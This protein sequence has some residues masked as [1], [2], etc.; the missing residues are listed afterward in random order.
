MFSFVRPEESRAGARAA[1]GDPGADPPGAGDPLP[2]RRHRRRRPRGR[3]GAQV[4]L[5]GLD[6][7]PGAL[8]RGD[9]LLEHDGLPGAAPR[10]ALP[11][12]ARSRRP[13]T[14]TP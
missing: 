13:C 4:R 8:P 1:A 5:R 12:G 7:E 11:P 10:R 14:L 9:L 2:R 3:G 6:P